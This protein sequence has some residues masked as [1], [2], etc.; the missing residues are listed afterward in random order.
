ML[1]YCSYLFS[2]IFSSLRYS[3]GFS[4]FRFVSVILVIKKSLKDNSQ[5]L[6]SE[7]I[8]KAFEISQIEG[9]HRRPAFNK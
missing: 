6:I 4:V 7:G 5:R 2:S 1:A 8:G 9:S 3:V